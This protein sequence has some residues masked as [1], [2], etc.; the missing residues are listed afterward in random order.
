MSRKEMVYTG[1]ITLEVL[2]NGDMD[3]YRWA[4]VSHGSHPSAYVAPPPGHPATKM[5][6]NFKW[7]GLNC[8]KVH[9]GITYAKFGLWDVDPKGTL[10]WLGWD[11]SHGSDFVDCGKGLT[12]GTK[13]YTVADLLVD[14]EAAVL[15]LKAMQG[16]Q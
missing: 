9:G 6:R 8:V 13:K 4:V 16:V 14:I 12:W 10:F 1:D 15:Q 2:A 7:T 5:Y 11:Y 3:G